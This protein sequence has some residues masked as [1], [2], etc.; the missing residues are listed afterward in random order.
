MNKQRTHII[1]VYPAVKFGR[2][3][4]V[5]QKIKRGKKKQGKTE[6]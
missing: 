6:K 2:I 4:H 1:M 5:S 3:N